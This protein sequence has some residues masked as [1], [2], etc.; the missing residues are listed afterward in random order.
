MMTKEEKKASTQKILDNLRDV[1][2]QGIDIEVDGDLY[3]YELI[4]QSLSVYI[5]GAV[6][7]VSMTAPT[8]DKMELI[9]LVNKFMMELTNDN[10]T[11]TKEDVLKYVAAKEEMKPEKASNVIPFGAKTSKYDN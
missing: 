5:S 9:A 10:N 8:D 4:Y 7:V 3:P 1:I 11:V 2:F 6:Q